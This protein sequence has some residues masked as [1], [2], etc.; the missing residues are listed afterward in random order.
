MFLKNMKTIE[1]VKEILIRKINDE[2]DLHAILRNS[3]LARQPA[4][5]DYILEQLAAV[6]K[7]KIATLEDILEQVKRI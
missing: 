7:T 6:H 4:D 3:I 1:K 5:M 2:N